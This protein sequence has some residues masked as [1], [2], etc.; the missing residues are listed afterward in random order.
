[1]GRVIDPTIFQKYQPK[2]KVFPASISLLTC[3]FVFITCSLPLLPP[4]G[5]KNSKFKISI[6][7]LFLK[8]WS[9]FLVKTVEKIDI[10]DQLQ[11]KMTFQKFSTVLTIL[12]RDHI[13]KIVFWA[14]NKILDGFLGRI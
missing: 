7:S 13:L 6:F 14:P 1:M 9:F 11:A 2:K 10:F 4:T 5:Y 12:T 3:F 8:K